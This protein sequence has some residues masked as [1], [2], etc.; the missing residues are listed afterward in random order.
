MSRDSLMRSCPKFISCSAPICPLDTDWH[1]REMTNCDSVC[2]F[3][4]GWSKVVSGMS[5]EA[6]FRWDVQVE[7]A[8][9]VQ[10]V[11]TEILSHYVPMKKAL[12]RASRTGTR[13]EL[14]QA[15][16]RQKIESN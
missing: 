13:R 3:L 1:I 12:K 10:E 7:I 9:R 2:P 16:L 14:F 15:R 4:L 6:V 11:Y 5:Q 8:D